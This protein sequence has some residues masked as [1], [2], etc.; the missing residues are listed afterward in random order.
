[1]NS[2]PEAVNDSVIIASKSAV[3]I[4]VLGNDTDAD[5]DALQVTS[6]GRSSLGTVELLANG[7]I[8]YTPG[9][10]FKSTDSFSYTISDGK[11]SATATVTI[12]LSSTDSG[13]N[14]GGNKG[15]GKH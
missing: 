11:E 5:D 14:S 3:S 10:R 15:K 2:A 9:K 8:R 13:G 4:N 6:F 7:Q 1:V 12:S